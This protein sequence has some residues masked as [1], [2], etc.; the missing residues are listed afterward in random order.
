MSANR[1]AADV[2][3]HPVGD[4]RGQARVAGAEVEVEPAVVV[5]V[6]EVAAHRGEDHVE[7]GFRGHVLECLA[8]EVAEQPVGR[9]S[10]RLADHALDDVDRASRS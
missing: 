8:A 5:E 3:E 4:Q 10:V 9:R 2:L 1:L 6:G 7:A